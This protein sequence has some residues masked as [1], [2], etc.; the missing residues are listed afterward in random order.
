MSRRT[1]QTNLKPDDLT[2]TLAELKHVIE[3]LKVVKL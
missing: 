3:K 2:L 1:G